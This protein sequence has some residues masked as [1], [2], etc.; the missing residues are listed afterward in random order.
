MTR[1]KQLPTLGSCG[2]GPKAGPGHDLAMMLAGLRVHSWRGE[3]AYQSSSTTPRTPFRN[4]GGS[5]TASSSPQLAGTKTARSPID[6]HVQ[7]LIPKETQL[8]PSPVPSVWVNIIYKIRIASS[9]VKHKRMKKGNDGKCSM[10][11]LLSLS[12]QPSWKLS[13]QDLVSG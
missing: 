1:M 3:L 10:R 12:K 8:F 7:A 9:S 2:T 5:I 11:R 6:G 4:V 13:I